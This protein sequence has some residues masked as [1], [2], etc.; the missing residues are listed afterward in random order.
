MV[1]QDINFTLNFVDNITASVNRVEQSV[2]TLSN[3]MDAMTNKTNDQNIGFLTQVQAV[4]S[5]DMGLRGIASVTGIVIGEN[6]ILTRSL[7]GTSVAV[8]GISSAFQ[9]LK[10][11]RQVL[12]MLRSAEV[13]LATVESFRAGLKGKMGLVFLGL[14]GAAG[15][16]GYF[17]GQSSV[18]NSTS[19]T[20]NV[21]FGMTSGGGTLHYSTESEKR[22]VARDTMSTL[23]GYY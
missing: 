4:R 20:Q 2:G 9:L 8:H 6:N 12:M 1:D 23:G 18:N 11:A 21:S 14:A 22:A 19:V 10:G 7:K 16:A 17:A 13:G 15:T 3:K 5:V